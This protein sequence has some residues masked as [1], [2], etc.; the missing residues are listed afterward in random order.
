M[1]R[2]LSLSLSSFLIMS[3]HGAYLAANLLPEE[4]VHQGHIVKSVLLQQNVK[5]SVLKF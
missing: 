3:N 1:K 5:S 4:V 2:F